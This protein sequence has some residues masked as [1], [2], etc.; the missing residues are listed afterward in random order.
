MK[1]L[2]RGWVFGKR[3]HFPYRDRISIL[4]DE[5]IP[6]DRGYLWGRGWREKAG[7]GVS[8]LRNGRRNQAQKWSRALY[9]QHF[10]R[11]NCHASP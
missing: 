2:I 10:H 4:W 5:G 6:E 1:I 8:P 11:K 3:D 7:I 9:R